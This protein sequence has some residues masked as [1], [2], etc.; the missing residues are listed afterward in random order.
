MKT[1]ADFF[2]KLG[3][4]EPRV[5]QKGVFSTWLSC[6]TVP[7]IGGALQFV[8][9]RVLGLRGEEEHEC[10][11]VPVEPGQFVVEFRGVKYGCDGRIAAMRVFAVGATPKRGKKLKEIP[12]DLG[13]IAVVDIG[14]VHQS[15]KEKQAIHEKW[16]EKILY[17]DDESLIGVCVWRPTKTEILYVDGGF[18]DGTYPV[19]QL[20]SARKVVGLEIEFISEGEVY[21]L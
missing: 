11:E 5:G 20:V 4:R 14:A 12:V 19:Y 6:G 16:M 7:I 17:G 18:G 13:G 2:T 3:K 1:I 9:L 21:P 15:M 10:V 8:E